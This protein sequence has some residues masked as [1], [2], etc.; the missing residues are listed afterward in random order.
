MLLRAATAL[1]PE[2]VEISVYESLAKLPH[3]NV[4]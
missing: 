2:G 1:A 3:F 4:V